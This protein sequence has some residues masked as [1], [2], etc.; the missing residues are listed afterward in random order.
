MDE[1]LVAVVKGLLPGGS[2]VVKIYKDAAGEI[3][4]DVK[5]PGGAG[6]MTCSLKKNHSGQLYVE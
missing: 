4:V 5:L 3:K 1:K 6:D 2:D